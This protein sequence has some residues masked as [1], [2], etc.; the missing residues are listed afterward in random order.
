MTSFLPERPCIKNKNHLSIKSPEEKNSIKHL[1]YILNHKWLIEV[2]H[3]YIFVM[4]SLNQK[5]L[6]KANIWLVSRFVTVSLI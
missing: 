3:I 4:V 2:F 5:K 6:L 1:R